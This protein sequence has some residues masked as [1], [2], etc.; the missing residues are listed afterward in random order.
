MAET[1]SSII[2]EF[3]IFTKDFHIALDSEMPQEPPDAI[4]LVGDIA[5]TPELFEKKWLSLT[6]DRCWDIKWKKDVEPDLLQSSLHVLNIY[7]IAKSKAGTQPW[8]S[9]LYAKDSKENMFLVELMF[10]TDSYSLITTV[11][12][13]TENEFALNDF[14]SL[15]QHAVSAVLEISR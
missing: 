13:D 10:C 3:F 4:T 6:T 11:K 9:Y 1:G 7:T 12:Q 8:K 15:L 5:I 2:H 14:I